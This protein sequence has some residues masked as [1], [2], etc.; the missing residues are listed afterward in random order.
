MKIRKKTN[1]LLKNFCLI[2]LFV[3]FSCSSIHEEMPVVQ[4]DSIGIITHNSA[5]VYARVSDDGGSTPYQGGTVWS[6]TPGVTLDDTITTVS[7]RTYGFVVP[8]ADLE[9]NK[10]YYIRPF[11][12]DHRGKVLGEE[13]SF[14]TKT[15][16]TIIDLRDGNV[17][18]VLP[19]GNLVWFAENLRYNSAEG[20]VPVLNDNY[21]DLTMFGNLYTFETAQNVCPE[22]WRLSTDNDW[23]D[24]ERFVGVPEEEIDAARTTNA[25]LQLIYPGEKYYKYFNNGTNRTGYSDLPAGYYTKDE[26]YSLFGSSIIFWSDT[27]TNDEAIKRIFDHDGGIIYR[28]HDYE[29]NNYYYSVRC[30]KDN[31]Q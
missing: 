18:P 13:I 12:E 11:C 22:G 28:E 20:C 1:S 6:D 8:V 24:L 29:T 10:T 7:N 14:T 5:F 9:A 15:V 30:V 21:T 3:L 25:G 31:N 4:I 26:G 16:E 23:K 19:L 2:I 17:Y 27:M